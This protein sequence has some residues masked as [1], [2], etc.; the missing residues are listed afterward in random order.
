MS[1]VLESYIQ[2]F[3]KLTGGYYEFI[4]TYGRAWTPKPNPDWLKLGRAKMCYENAGRIAL[5]REDLIYVEGVALRLIPVPHA[6]LVTLDGDVIDPTWQSPETC[7]YFGLAFKRD[8]L[9][10]N[11]L[12]TETWGIMGE[13][14]PDDLI[15]NPLP[16]MH[17]LFVREKAINTAE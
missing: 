9:A 15:E 2:Q 8:Y 11:I 16:A 3:A 4:S 10:Q 13:F 1:N 17:P 12:T 5:Q 14:V 6:W 7:Q